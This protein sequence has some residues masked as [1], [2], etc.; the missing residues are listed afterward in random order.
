MKVACFDGIFG[1]VSMWC[2]PFKKIQEI[3]LFFIFTSVRKKAIT[4]ADTV[5]QKP[6]SNIL[7]SKM[8]L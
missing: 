1:L 5:T 3:F 4:I 7:V 2:C 6:N 8:F